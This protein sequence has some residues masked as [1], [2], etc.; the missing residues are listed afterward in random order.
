MY[1]GNDFSD[2]GPEESRIY[3]FDFTNDLASGETIESATWACEVFANEG[4]ED[5]TPNDK[6][7]GSISVASPYVSQ[8]VVGLVAGVVYRQRCLATTS[9]GAVLELYSHVRCK[10][11]A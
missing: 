5:E 11:P 1:V 3:T 4:G 8:K 2:A 9:R 6:I 10:D 7:S